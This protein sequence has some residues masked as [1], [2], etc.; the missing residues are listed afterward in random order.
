MVEG[1]N[2]GEYLTSAVGGETVRASV[3]APLPP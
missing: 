2:S 3:P 1:G